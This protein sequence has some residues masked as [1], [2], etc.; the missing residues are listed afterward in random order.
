MIL[1]FSQVDYMLEKNSKYHSLFHGERDVKPNPVTETFPTQI[2]KFYFDC[3]GSC[4]V[5]LT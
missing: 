3:I 2:A 4:P 5:E 1:S